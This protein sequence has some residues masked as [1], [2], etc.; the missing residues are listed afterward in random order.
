MLTRLVLN[1]LMIVYYVVYDFNIIKVILKH[2][3]LLPS[4]YTTVITEKA[5]VKRLYLK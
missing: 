3:M 4:A 1:V 2:K 5:A